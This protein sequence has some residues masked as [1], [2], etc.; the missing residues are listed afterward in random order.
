MCSSSDTILDH[1]RPTIQ[2]LTSDVRTSLPAAGF[3]LK[4]GSATQIVRCTACLCS[5][6]VFLR[7]LLATRARRHKIREGKSWCLCDLVADCFYQSN[8]AMMGVWSLGRFA[9]RGFLSM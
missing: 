9:R 7:G 5:P 4:A 3:H 8:S 6:V 2:S 1:R